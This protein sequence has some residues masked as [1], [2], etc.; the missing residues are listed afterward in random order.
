MGEV[1]SRELEYAVPSQVV[2]LTFDHGSSALI[3][4]HE[5]RPFAEAI[6]FA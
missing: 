6:E 3:S 4:V 1:P 5:A 2:P